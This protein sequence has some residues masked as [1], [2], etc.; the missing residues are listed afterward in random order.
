MY[1]CGFAQL[2]TDPTHFKGNILDLASTN[3]PDFLANVRPCCDPFQ[4]ETNHH[5][6]FLVIHDNISD[7]IS[8][9]IK[10][11]YNY[12]RTNLDG[13]ADYL[14]DYNFFSCISSSGIEMSWLIL[15]SII[16]RSVKI[17]LPKVKMWAHPSPKWFTSEIK[18]GL[19]VVHTLRKKTRQCHDQS[20]LNLDK[21]KKEGE[22]LSLL[23]LTA[24]SKFEADFPKEFISNSSRVY[25]YIRS[26]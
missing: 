20:S 26:L 10:E 18:H 19:H 1:D 22:N 15:K 9:T 14:L 6:I 17:F 8:S 11:V 23:M 16:T 12:F 13:S 5:T 7:T 24:N 25:T 2:I 21:W 4:I 3:N